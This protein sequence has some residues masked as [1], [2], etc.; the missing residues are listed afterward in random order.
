MKTL[1]KLLYGPLA[2]STAYVSQG[3][4]NHHVFDI[5]VISVKCPRKF[6]WLVHTGDTIPAF[7]NII[8][9]M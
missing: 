2:Y 4:L 8:K 1:I 3:I 9:S 5:V 6:F 7:R